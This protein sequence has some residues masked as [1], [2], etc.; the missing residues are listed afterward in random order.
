MLRSK[1][2]SEEEKNKLVRKGRK[3]Q[4]MIRG[5]GIYPEETGLCFFGI[6]TLIFCLFVLSAVSG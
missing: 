6:G 4:E 3:M 1:W 2:G 5:E